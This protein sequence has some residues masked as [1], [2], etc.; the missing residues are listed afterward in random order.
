ME[1]CN[2]CSSRT[3]KE[4]IEKIQTGDLAAFNN[5]YQ[6]YSRELQSFLRLKLG[7]TEDAEDVSQA[8]WQKIWQRVST[9]SHQHT[10]KAWM[11][12]IAIHAIVDH[13]RRHGKHY[14]NRIKI[15]A[16]T[17]P[18][19]IAQEDPLGFMTYF[20]QSEDPTNEMVE[21]RETQRVVRET[22][23]TMIIDLQ[24]VVNLVFFEEKSYGEA[25]RIVGVPEG[26]IKSRVHTAKKVLREKR[27]LKKYADAE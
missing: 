15:D 4:L 5:L 9:Y 21:R 19:G 22:V 18:I 13:L 11:Y 10:F 3:D 7:S 12:G 2:S 26:T 1:N 8:T 6:K 16:I 27:K 25:A 17:S 14:A 23:E 24:T 20:Q